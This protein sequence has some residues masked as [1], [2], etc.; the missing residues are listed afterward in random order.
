LTKKQG[1]IDIACHGGFSTFFDLYRQFPTI[2]DFFR[3][4]STYL[5]YFRVF[6]TFLKP[7]VEIFGVMYYNFKYV[8]KKAGVRKS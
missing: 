7:Y 1:D 5:D 2:S 8:K 6:S 4:F 3:P